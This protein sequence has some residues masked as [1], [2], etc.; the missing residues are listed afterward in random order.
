MPELKAAEENVS[1]AVSVAQEMAA[2][3]AAMLPHIVGAILVLFIGLWLAGRVRALIGA[4]LA[5][6]KRVDKT[7]AGFLTSLAHYAL[8]ALV[9][10]STLGVFGVPTTTFAAVIG[11]AGLAI[12]LALQGT[13]S[14]VASGGMLLGFRPFA[15]G[16]F[17]EAAGV[18]GTVVQINLFTTEIATIDN[19]KVIIPNGM[20]FQNVIVNYAGYR[21]RR[22]DLVFGV[23]YGDNLDKAMDLIRSEIGKEERI[24]KIPEPQLGVDNLGASSVDIVCRVWVDRDNYFPV[25]WSLIKAVKERFDAEGVTIPFPMRTVILQRESG[26]PKAAAD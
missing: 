8:I 26:E 15:V 22:V 5:R 19:K 13:L 20:I 17:V 1:F 3:G 25:K 6:A 14:H 21:T 24:K 10:I 4:A 18:S 11:A 2:K 12:G 16:D 9:I 23:S 7:L